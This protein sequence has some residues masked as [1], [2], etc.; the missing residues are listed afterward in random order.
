LRLLEAVAC[1]LQR[2]GRLVEL[3]L[4]ANCVAATL[5]MRLGRL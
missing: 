4:E 2:I 1:H 3:L 5:R